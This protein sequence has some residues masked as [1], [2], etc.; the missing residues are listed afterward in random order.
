MGRA[1][2]VIRQLL[3]GSGAVRCPLPT[4]SPCG[5]PP[6]RG[7]AILK[8]LDAV[9]V[10]RVHKWLGR[11][12]SEAME[13]RGGLCTVNSGSEGTRTCGGCG[14]IALSPVVG[15]VGTRRPPNC[16]PAVILP[17]L[18]SRNSDLPN[19]YNQPN[20]RVRTRMYGGGGRG[21]GGLIRHSP[22]PDL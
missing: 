1:G 3:Y 12:T 6:G 9:A 2:R 4:S 18:G 5:C 7:G 11:L 19:L 16:L 15:Y 20:R 22:Y 10:E 21:N 8:I 14:S 17:R 13:T